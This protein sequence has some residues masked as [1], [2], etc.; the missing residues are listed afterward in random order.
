MTSK[1]KTPVRSR[2]AR[3]KTVQYPIDSDIAK[4]VIKAL[5]SQASGGQVEPPQQEGF[6]HDIILAPQPQTGSGYSGGN[7]NDISSDSCNDDEN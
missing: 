3:Q 1:G 5:S 4:V 2:C 6:N 7:R